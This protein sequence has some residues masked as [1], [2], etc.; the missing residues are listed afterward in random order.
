MLEIERKFLVKSNDFKSLATS[1]VIIKQG[2]LTKDPERT[3]RIRLKNKQAFLT[4]KGISSSS[5]MS[6]FEWE[7]EIS[8]EDGKSLI[9]LCLPGV[10]EKVRYLIPHGKLII[11]VDVFGGKHKGLTLAEIEVP[12]EA[13]KLDLPQWI[14]QEVTGDKMYYNSYLSSKESKKSL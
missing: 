1:Q 6:R 11:E 14:G 13:T 2:Y 9:N 10:I 5:G 4:I 3:V 12:S 7:K 8:F